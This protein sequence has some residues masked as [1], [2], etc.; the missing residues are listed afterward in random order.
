MKRFKGDRQQDVERF[1]RDVLFPVVS[2]GVIITS[3]AADCDFASRF[4]LDA[5]GADTA[6]Q[7]ADA[8]LLRTLELRYARR[9]TLSREALHLACAFASLAAMTSGTRQEASYVEQLDRL[10]SQVSPVPTSLEDAI[11]R[12]IITSPFIDMRRTDHAVKTWVASYTYEGRNVPPRV[13][14]WPGV[15]NVTV[16]RTQRTFHETLGSAWLGH[17]RALRDR[18]PLT[19]WLRE[20]EVSWELQNPDFTPGMIALL[21]SH[22]A[23]M[24]VLR[25]LGVLSGTELQKWMSWFADKR[26]VAVIG[27]TD[28]VGAVLDRFGEEARELFRAR[29]RQDLLTSSA[30]RSSVSLN[31]R[32]T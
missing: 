3:H 31:G 11:A 18:S 16:N 23:R 4:T 13:V 10:L 5:C 1:A 21:G 32:T 15:R 20:F 17:Y 26:A 22:E 8:I 30:N 12:H 29:S 7:V 19:A 25:N 9:V 24:L 14:A 27:I 6:S 28:E 2:R